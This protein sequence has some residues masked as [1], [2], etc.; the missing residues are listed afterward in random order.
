MGKLK[1]DKRYDI[2]DCATYLISRFREDNQELLEIKLQK[3]LYFA[4]AFYMAANNANSLF[5]QGWLAKPYGPMNREVH[6]KFKNGGMPIDMS[7][8]DF[9]AVE[10]VTN[11][12]VLY[13][14]LDEI[15]AFFKDKSA[16]ELVE[17]THSD[18]SP[19]SEATKGMSGVELLNNETV[20]IS[21]ES[22]K[23]WIPNG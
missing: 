20:F 21:K 23:N 14:F 6:E 18:H 5:R 4:E 11:D 1:K 12:R 2:V 7:K 10:K 13:P 3:I 17:L 16:A 19:W 15:Y 22:T 9:S 8:V